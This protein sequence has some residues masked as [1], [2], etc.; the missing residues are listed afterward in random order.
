MSHF[1]LPE[2]D[3]DFLPPIPPRLEQFLASPVVTEFPER[4]GLTGPQTLR[5]NPATGQRLGAG[6]EAARG[7]TAR[8]VVAARAA[9]REWAATPATERAQVFLT[10]HGMIRRHEELLLD[11]I[12]AETG[13]ARA[14]AYDEILDAYNICR[15]VG[16]TAPKVLAE[17]GRRGAVPLL[18]RTRVQHVPVG[19]VGF[20]TPW[21]YPLSLGAN[22]LFSALAAGNAV[23]HKPDSRTTLT[24]VLMRELALRAGL[25][26]GVWRLVPGDPNTVGPELIAQADAVSFTGSTPAGRR[27]AAQTGM[28]LS[29]TTL[30]LGGK[31]PMIVRDDADLAQA[32]AGA[33]R[34]AFS[35]T[36]QL[37][38]SI[39]RIYVV[40]STERFDAFCRLLVREIS[41]LRV[42]FGYDHRF[43]LGSLIC[44]EHAER[45]DGFVRDAA[46][47]GGKVLIGG[48]RMPE[49]GDAFY[50]PT[51][52][53]D[54]PTTA[55]FFAEESFGPL[56]ALYRASDDDDAVARANATAYGLNACIYTADRSA[57]FDLASRLE[58]GMVNINE[59]FAAAWGSVDAPSGGFKASGLGVRHGAEGI[60]EFTRP[61]TIARHQGIPLGPTAS[62]G[63]ARFQK[64]MTASL[65][66]MKGIGL[67]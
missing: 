53:I 4:M 3:P 63:S 66:A 49:L 8:A 30:E 45:M 15:Y 59:P 51:V 56:V 27:I 46:R 48:R 64:A 6:R 57:G 62:W 2:P 61:R 44:A 36:G 42:G 16:R 21:N 23:V 67:K 60:L 50:T 35:S 39:E 54:V 13:K 18:T 52:L 55:R 41:A 33:V 58:T 24:A 10:L 19:V 22:D 34:G 25:P 14:H 29:P 32:V 20:I 12:Q 17:E 11:L 28:H 38:L 5:R 26:A 9:H 37:C 7:E 43:D 31:N 40:G 1:P 47:R 65:A